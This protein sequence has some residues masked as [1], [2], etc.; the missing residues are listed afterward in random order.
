MA[1]QISRRVRRYA[2]HP[3]FQN[4]CAP[5]HHSACRRRLR[6][7]VGARNKFT[8][9]YSSSRPTYLLVTG[10]GAL[11]VLPAKF[12]SSQGYRG[13]WP[14]S[15][16]MITVSG[17]N[18]AECGWHSRNAA[19]EEKRHEKSGRPWHARNRSWIAPKLAHVYQHCYPLNHLLIACDR[20][21]RHILLHRHPGR[22]TS[23]DHPLSTAPPPE[24]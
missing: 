11:S 15:V 22:K 18:S 16:L 7:R 19:Q 13:R 6:G 10:V 8:L 9:A 17:Q 5:P 2:D 23:A 4:A 20:R 21:S 1:S 3:L 24:Q 14:A 12:V